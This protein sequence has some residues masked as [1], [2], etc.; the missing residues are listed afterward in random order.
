MRDLSLDASHFD[1][2][3]NER[4]AKRRVDKRQGRSFMR[5]IFGARRLGATLILGIA[6]VAAIGVPMNA[7]FF[8][9]GRH[10]APLFSTQVSLAPKPETPT[11]PPRRVAIEPA[12]AVPEAAPAEAQRLAQMSA[13]AI[14]QDKID[15]G[16]AEAPPRAAEKKRDPIGQLLAN[17]APQAESVEKAAPA[18][19]NAAVEKDVLYAQRALLKLGYVVRADG[20]FGA[21][22]RQAL[23]AFERDSGL[24][25]KGELT[26]KLLRQLA[27]RSGLTRE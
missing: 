21:G 27:A 12:R 3:P 5:R 10:P 13:A 24:T 23:A 6:G 19:K 17:R 1:S 14:K 20:T 2:L 25:A 9:D 8:Q 16:K 7:L 22:T 11:P 15:A 18:D 4:A 26:P